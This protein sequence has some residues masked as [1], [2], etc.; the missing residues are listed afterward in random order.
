MQKPFKATDLVSMMDSLL[1]QQS[2]SNIEPLT[3]ELKSRSDA[4]VP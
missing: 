1:P 2:A 4:L 3:P